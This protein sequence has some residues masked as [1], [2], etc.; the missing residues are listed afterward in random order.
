MPVYGYSK[1]VVNEYGLHEMSEV[2]FNVSAEEL[3]RV[4]AFLIDCADMIDSRQ[5]RTDHMHIDRPW[6]EC[7]V[8][9]CHPNPDPPKRVG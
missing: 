5:W 6:D 9:V 3:R 8:I 2:T 4:A 1:R 7:D